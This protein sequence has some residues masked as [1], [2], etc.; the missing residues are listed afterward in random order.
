MTAQLAAKAQGIRVEVTGEH[1][2]SRRVWAEPD[3]SFSAEV[4]TGPNWVRQPNG[5]WAEVDTRLHEAPNGDVVP[6]AAAVDVSLAGDAASP[7]STGKTNDV[8]T[9]AIPTASLDDLAAAQTDPSVQV[10]ASPDAGASA[11]SVT[12]GTSSALPAPTLDDNEATYANVEPGKDL[13]IRVLPTGVQT[14]VDIKTRPTV[15]P[16]GGVQV[17]LPLSAKGLTVSETADGGFVLRDATTGDVVS[18]TP[19]ARVWD[20]SLEAASGESEHGFVADTDV[21]KTADG[22]KLI[23]TIPADYFDTPGLVYPITVDPTYTFG[24]SVLTDTYVEHGYDTTSFGT[25]P[26]LKVGTYDAGTHIGRSYLKFDLA[27]APSFMDTTYDRT[28]VDT[29]NLKVWEYWAANCTAT[30]MYIRYLTSSFSNSST[31]NTKPSQSSAVYTV[32]DAHRD[33][34]T[35]SCAQSWLDTTSGTTVKSIVQGWV[36]GTYANY[37]L[38]L[39]ASETSSSGWKR[40]YSKDASTSAYRPSLVVSYHHIPTT[41]SVLSLAGR[42]AAGWVRSSTPSMSAT[43]ADLDG[44][45]VAGQFYVSTSSSFTSTAWSGS[46]AVPTGSVATV[47]TTSLAQGTQYYARVRAAQTQNGVTDYSAYAPT[48]AFNVDSVAPTSAINCTGF[49]AGQYVSNLPGADVPCTVMASDATSGVTSFSNFTL[50]GLT[51]NILSIAG[52][53]NSRTFSL[54]QAAAGYGWHKVTTTVTDNAGNSTIATFEFGIGSSEM[55]LP[56]DKQTTSSGTAVL[57]VSAATGVSTQIQYSTDGS[58]WTTI[59]AGQLTTLAGGSVTTPLPLSGTPLKSAQVRWNMSAAFASDAVVSLRPCV[60]PSVGATCAAPTSG[61]PTTITL[62]RSGAG[63][64]ST[65]VGPFSVALTTGAASVGAM[66]ASVGG[67]SIG[68]FYSSFSPNVDG[69]FGKGWTTSLHT[70]AATSWSH[71][72]VTSAAL[73]LYASTGGDP[74]SFAS[75]GTPA[76]GCSASYEPADDNTGLSICV[77][78]SGSAAFVLTETD[79]PVTS[80]ALQTGSTYIVT[81][82]SDTATG[83]VTDF[84]TS[85][86]GITRILPPLPP[87]VTNCPW[88]NTAV[89]VAGCS[90]L[91]VTYSTSRASTVTWRGFEQ[92]LDGSTPVFRTY[93]VACYRYDTNGR[94]IQ[95]WD[96]R[97]NTSG[98]AACG[99]G[100]APLS[101]LVTGYGYDASTGRLT[102]ITPPGLQPWTIS[103]DTTSGKATGVSR[104]HTSAFNSGATETT[105]IQYN[106]PVGSATS[107]DDTHPDL[108]ETAV[109]T[110]WPI[111]PLV[112][113]PIAPAYATAVYPPGVVTTDLKNATITAMDEY[114]RAYMTANYSGTGQSGWKV[115][116]QVLDPAAGAVLASLT[117]GNRDAALDPSSLVRV[118]VGLSGT[119]AEAAR[120]LAATTVSTNLVDDNGDGAINTEDI[121]DVT[122]T[123]GPLHM[124]D[125]NGTDVAVRTHTHTSYGDV[126]TDTVPITAADR[127]SKAAVHQ[128]LQVTEGGWDPSTGADVVGSVKTTRYAYAY[129]VGSTETQAGWTFSTPIQ[130]TIVM[131]GGTDIVTRTLLDAT[132]GEVLQQ[133]QPS[134]KD[135]S[136]DYVSGSAQASNPGTR[137]VRT[138]QTGSYNEANCTATVWYGLPCEAKPANGSLPAATKTFYDLFGRAIKQLDTAA[139]ATRT[140]TTSYANSG[141]SS[142]SVDVTITGG[143]AGDTAVPDRTFTYDMPTGL[144]TGVT[145]GSGGSS[146]TTTTSLDDFGR[147]RVSADGTGGQVAVTYGDTTGRLST[148]TRTQNGSAVGTTSYTYNS[149]TERRGL[150][151]SATHSTLGTVSATYDADGQPISQV[152]PMSSGTL[153]QSWT[154]SATGQA[155]NL[156]WV[157]SG[158][159]ENWMTNAVTV[160]AHGRVVSDTSNLYAAGGRVREYGYD[161]AGRLTSV[162]DKRAAAC[163]TRTYGFDINSNRTSNASYDP[164]ADNSC[165]TTTTAASTTNTF[166]AAD[167]PTGSTLA[168]DAFGRTTTLPRGQTA[169]PTSSDV[170][171]TYYANDL[172]RSTTVTSGDV[173]AVEASTTWTLDALNR[174]ACRR[175]KP[176]A[177]TDATGCGATT[178][179][180]VTDTINHYDG[181]SDSPGWTITRL[182]GTTP[183]ITTAWYVAGLAGGMIATV[184]GGKVIVG[185]A[186]LHGDIPLTTTSTQAVSPDGTITDTDEYGIVSD[187][188]GGSTAGPRYAWLGTAQRDATAA[189]GLTLM[190]VR[191]YNPVTGRFLSTDLV[192]GG[193]STTYS[194]PDDPV[195]KTD[196][197]GRCWSWAS[198]LCGA[199]DSFNGEAWA[200]AMSGYKCGLAVAISKSV[201]WWAGRTSFRNSSVRNAARHFVWQMMLMWAGGQRLANIWAIGHE[202]GSTD[203]LDTWVDWQNNRAAWRYGWAVQLLWSYDA[204]WRYSMLR[205]NSALHYHWLTCATIDGRV[206][207]C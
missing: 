149:S 51:T 191:L 141:L 67:A 113:K 43:V 126:P 180:G 139:S 38:A 7:P 85:G 3:G 40:F 60:L 59:P 54:K 156:E 99:T 37:G 58:N 57:E 192:Y 122:D 127:A 86:V 120:M 173:A 184:A 176:T 121:A 162:T 163:T 118:D 80:F 63:A 202:M 183:T 96:P 130:T 61:T 28:V 9:V 35:G 74:I 34:S 138:W 42:N 32:T 83:E 134:A 111:D 159:T 194:Y 160:D 109:G 95:V 204:A 98:Y 50:D 97:D 177:T 8:A 84:D 175:D 31:W 147:P 154:R 82:V 12:I 155:T 196:V 10:P 22:Y 104:T 125:V 1:T 20:A 181:G 103:Y 117:P 167:Q 75:L 17:A 178:T 94:L 206:Y 18:K 102:S 132:T 145:S 46:V 205:L 4:Y 25:D 29:A 207:K 151:A 68:R 49:T 73:L 165:Q 14:F 52:T 81:A 190:G 70:A 193:N 53:G 195:N 72:V 110:W 19:A 5:S 26:D 116:T 55:S 186:D 87:G 129:S 71:L 169:T 142:R 144:P 185:L 187:G 33:D 143:A 140:T 2:E 91:L 201:E 66:D 123:Y 128:V 79:G 24:T 6:Q 197:T 150:P 148:I 101:A 106:A 21:V 137:L 90:D 136:I 88:N 112:V 198:W 115:A 168:Y 13:R 107:T 124:V 135:D 78:A 171:L 89:W 164:A 158:V 64:A 93:D 45:N 161:P 108:T 100:G 23:V 153:T 170:G 47:T 203:P 105:T 172:I 69:P 182:G 36:N 77:P 119:S 48:V 15:I 16:T 11:A 200:C 152:I 56:K 76:S 41:P 179:T 44:G 92:P 189:N 166:S 199:W 188:A 157:R 30:A 131:P 146:I 39:T 133:R 62:D 27:G 114:G 65:T 174:F